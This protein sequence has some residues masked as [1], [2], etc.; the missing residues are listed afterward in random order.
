MK[1]Q[2]PTETLTKMMKKKYFLMIRCLRDTKE[3]NLNINFKKWL[4]IIVFLI[5]EPF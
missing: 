2:L 5:N 1:P 3:A 4:N